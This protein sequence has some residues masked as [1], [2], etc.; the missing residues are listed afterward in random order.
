MNTIF[1]KVKGIVSGM[2]PTADSFSR[3]GYNFA[4]ERI[5]QNSVNEMLEKG[6]EYINPSFLM[7]IY[8]C[9]N[10]LVYLSLSREE[11]L[12]VDYPD[13][14]EY[15]RE[16]TER[17]LESMD[18]AGKLN[19]IEKKL[20]L[21]MNNN[22]QIIVNSIETRTP[23]GKRISLQ[24]NYHR[25]NIPCS[26]GN[27]EIAKINAKKQDNRFGTLLSFDKLDDLARNNTYFN[28]SL[29]MYLSSFHI[30]HKEPGF[31]LLVSAL[32]SILSK[33]TYEKVERCP[34][35]GNAIWSIGKSWT[36][37]I[38]LILYIAEEESG[39][40]KRLYAKRSKY[41]HEGKCN[42]SEEDFMLM[43]EYTWKVLL[44]YWI[45]SVAIRE[46]NHKRIMQYIHS[47]EYRTN[48]IIKSFVICLENVA[49][50]ERKGEIIKLAQI[51]D[52]GNQI[53]H[54]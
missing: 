11:K 10:D 1:L 40:I 50:S 22:I 12:D 2:Y 13:K 41:V 36:S 17:Y 5:D 51:E 47:E 44:V 14:H 30:A 34:K 42:I 49:F 53:N 24:Y 43:Q 39:A 21:E 4:W 28:N 48:V 9:E 20:T 18:I 45:T 26:L 31:V 37:N 35:C 19:D 33:S 6:I 29:N 3:Y 7:S 54:P 46:T 8:P 38:C 23:E 27:I 15:D 25:L 32:E 16:Y 52:V